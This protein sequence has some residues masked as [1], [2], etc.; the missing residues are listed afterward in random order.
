MRVVNFNQYGAPSVLELGELEKPTPGPEDVL[1]RVGAVEVTKSDCELRAMR[2]PV[3]WFAWPLRLLFGWSKPKKRVLGAYLSGIVEAVGERVTQWRIGDEVFGSTGMRFGGY[4]EFALASATATLAKKPRNLNFAEAA[5]IPLGGLNAL[6]FMNDAGDLSG[7]RLL[8]IGAGGSIGS[9]ALQIA[10]R[11]GAHVT[12]VDAAHKLAWLSGLGADRVVDYTREDALAAGDAYD[13]IFATVAGGHFDRCLRA[14][15]VGGCYLTAN[16]RLA[17]MLRTVW[18]NLTSNKRASFAFAR[19]TRGE[20]DTLR[21][22]AE[23]GEL[24]VS[25]DSVVSLA[26][27]ARAHARVET[28]QRTGAVVIEVMGRD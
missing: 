5:A 9:F 27:A 22:M 2:F 11:R 18:T 1:I 7:K 19:E 3:R 12:A 20:L 4:A 15:K 17:D 28:E 23:A 13:V 14:V 26:D 25:L 24:S 16:P 21:E 10:K 8:I 6:H